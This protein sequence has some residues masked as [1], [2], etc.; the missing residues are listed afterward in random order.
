MADPL[1]IQWSEL[2]CWV[3]STELAELVFDGL[4]SDLPLLFVGW[5]G[6]DG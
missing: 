2:G 5:S 3:V 1:E 6:G 4:L